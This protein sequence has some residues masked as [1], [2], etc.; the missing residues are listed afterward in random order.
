MSGSLD[1][2]ASYGILFTTFLSEMIPSST[3]SLDHI[4]QLFISYDVIIDARVSSVIASRL[5]L[6]TLH[7]VRTIVTPVH[8]RIIDLSAVIV[9]VKKR[10]GTCKSIW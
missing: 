8:K 5:A 3:G 10:Q 2:I 6:T 4:V 9:D 7:I 1:F